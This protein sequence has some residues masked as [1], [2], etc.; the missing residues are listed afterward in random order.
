MREDQEASQKWSDG[1]IRKWLRG[2]ARRPLQQRGIVEDLLNRAN[3]DQ[4]SI[5]DRMVCRRALTLLEVT[6]DGSRN[7]L[8]VLVLDQRWLGTLDDKGVQ[9]Q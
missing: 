7:N 4:M 2:L 1:D 8:P 6:L 9:V 3:D 5:E